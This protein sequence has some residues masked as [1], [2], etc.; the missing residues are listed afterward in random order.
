[1]FEVEIFGQVELDVGLTEDGVVTRDSNSILRD[2]GVLAR[3]TAPEIFDRTF[4]IL[5]F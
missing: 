1:M 3:S 2:R 4:S 5:I